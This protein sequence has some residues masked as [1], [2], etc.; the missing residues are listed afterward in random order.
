VS[1]PDD[2]TLY[3][4]CY[5]AAHGRCDTSCK[6]YQ[7]RRQDRRCGPPCKRCGT[8]RDGQTGAW[9]CLCMREIVKEASG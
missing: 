3:A 4:G 5:G 1:Q 7:P 2:C 6:G 8:P 9:R